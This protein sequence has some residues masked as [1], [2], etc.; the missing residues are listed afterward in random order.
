M[1][2]KK[3]ILT[4]IEAD[5]TISKL[6]LTLGDIEIDA[7]K[8]QTDISDVVLIMMGF[9]KESE[10]ENLHEEYFDFV[11]QVRY[12]NL[13]DKSAMYCLTKKIFDFLESRL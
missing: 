5:L 2:K 9:N 12:L 3:Q 7:D 8:F 11:K 6:I 10:F 13:S 1:N 4:L